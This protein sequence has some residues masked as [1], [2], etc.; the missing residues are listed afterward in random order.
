VIVGYFNVIN[1]AI[2]PNETDAEL[3][4]DANC[5]LTLSITGQRVQSV[6]W[7]QV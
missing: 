7:R 2:P 5:V 3:I 6:L 1:I 4:V